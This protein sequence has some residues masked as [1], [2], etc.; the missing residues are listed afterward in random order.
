[1]IFLHLVQKFH[2]LSSPL[3][4]SR[5]TSTETFQRK[6]PSVLPYSNP[7][8]GGSSCGSGAHPQFATSLGVVAGLWTVVSHLPVLLAGICLA[9]ACRED[10]VRFSEFQC[11]A[12]SEPRCVAR[13]NSHRSACC[14]EHF[15]RVFEVLELA[16]FLSCALYQRF[17]I[18][19]HLIYFSQAGC[20]QSFG[21]RWSK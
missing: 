10:S 2:I 14:P 6:A 5:L 9:G 17:P 3:S 11:V 21:C 8:S 7:P 15:P 4:Q 1:M 20:E 12:Y 18:A 13:C 19:R 16:E